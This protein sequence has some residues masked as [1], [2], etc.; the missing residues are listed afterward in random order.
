MP[1]IVDKKRRVAESMAE[2]ASDNRHSIFLPRLGKRTQPVVLTPET[3]MVVLKNPPIGQKPR[4][5]TG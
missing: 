1:T 2:M 3:S 5:R 4:P